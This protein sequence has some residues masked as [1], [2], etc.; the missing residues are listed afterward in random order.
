VIVN[1]WLVYTINITCSL[2]FTHTSACAH[3]HTHT[4]M[5]CRHSTDRQKAINSCIL[6]NFM[7]VT[8]HLCHMKTF[9]VQKWFLKWK[10]K[11][12][13][14]YMFILCIFL[15]DELFSRIL[16]N[17]TWSL[18]TMRKF[19]FNLYVKCQFRQQPHCSH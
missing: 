5:P 16:K 13:T 9:V 6:S 12:L 1:R 15:Q 7:T 2:F 18:R 10:L 17:L 19:T 14:K 11:I 4:A 3:T 8:I